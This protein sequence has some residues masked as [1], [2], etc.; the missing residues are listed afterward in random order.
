MMYK[1][2]IPCDNDL[3]FSGLEE[4]HKCVENVHPI[5]RKSSLQN[6]DCRIAFKIIALGLGFICLVASPMRIKAI[7]YFS[8]NISFSL[9]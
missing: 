8:A 4:F 3:F 7:L 2:Q 5:S 6:P 9:G 1:K